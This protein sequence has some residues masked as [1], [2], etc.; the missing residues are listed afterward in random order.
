[1]NQRRGHHQVLPGHVE[2]HLLHQ[3]DVVE[4][5]L[6]DERDGNI[7]DV[8]LALANQMQQQIERTLEGVELDPVRVRGRFEPVILHGVRQRAESGSMWLSSEA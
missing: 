8:H 2:V 5:L 7:V 1:V 3:L 6:G 4:V